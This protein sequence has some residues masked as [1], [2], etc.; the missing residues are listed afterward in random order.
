MITYPQY[1]ELPD[2]G[3]TWNNS[4][5]VPFDF[6][7]GW[8]LQ[9]DVSGY[10]PNTG[11]PLKFTKTTG[12]TLYPNLITPNIVI[13]WATTGEITILQP[14]LYTFQLKATQTSTSKV[15]YLDDVLK[16]TPTI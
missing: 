12:I 10:Y 2:L 8:T 3:V 6:T 11:T 4:A 15:R 16:I 1:A 14:G 7:S 9:C 5:G 13:T